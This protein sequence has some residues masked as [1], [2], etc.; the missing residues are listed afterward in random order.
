MAEDVE[1][2]FVVETSFAQQ[3]MWL[4]HQMDPTKPTCNITAAAR[5][6][7]PLGTEALRRALAAVIDRHEALR[8]VFRV[9]DGVPVQ[10]VRNRM[11][12]PV[13]VVDTH[14]SEVEASFRPRSPSTW[15]TGR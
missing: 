13:P 12:V 6:R 9:E 11:D 7:G 5:V 4:Q 15:S 10:V 14:P 2:V 3:S 1:D 8:T